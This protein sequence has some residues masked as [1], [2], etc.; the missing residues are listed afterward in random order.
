MSELSRLVGNA[1]EPHKIAHDGKTYSFYLLDQ[2]RKSALEKRLYQ[3]AREGVYVDRDHLTS[4]EYCSRLD[5][6]REKYELG[7]YGFFGAR[8]QA[9]LQT[10]KGVVM[11]LEVV[12]GESEDELVPLL[13][14]R[15]EEVNV[16]LKTVLEESFKRPRKAPANG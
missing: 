7:E 2:V 1:G 6:V 4:E 12:T 3:N 9:V 11:L 8:A 5:A 16:L 14:A 13:A 15:Q 10:P